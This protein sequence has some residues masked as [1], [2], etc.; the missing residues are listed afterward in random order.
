MGHF[1]FKGNN[2]KLNIM[3]IIKKL[4]DKVE[5]LLLTPD[6]YWRKNGAIIG[7]CCEI[8]KTASLGSEPY[9]IEIGDHVRINP[10]VVFVNH[11][12]EV[13][14]IRNLSEWGGI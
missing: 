7:K 12:G 5:Q 10:G 4:T 8:Y 9:L 13:W 6:K 1:V 14:V 11:D 2:Y 3:N